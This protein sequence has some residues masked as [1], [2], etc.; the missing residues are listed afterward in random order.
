MCN[1]I[2]ILKTT[3]MSCFW[4]LL[5]AK[6][7]LN[8]YLSFFFYDGPH[9]WWH[10]CVIWSLE[11]EVAWRG[12]SYHCTSHEIVHGFRLCAGNL[13]MMREVPYFKTFIKPY[14]LKKVN[15][16]LDIPKFNITISMFEMMVPLPCNWSFY[17]RHLIRS[18]RTV[19]SFGV[20]TMM[21]NVCCPMGS[22]NLAHET[23]W[24]MD[25]KLFKVHPDS[26]N[27]G[28]SCM[29]RTSPNVFMT[30]M[31]RWW[32]IGIVFDQS[33]WHRSSISVCLGHKDFSLRVGWQIMDFNN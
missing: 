14:M 22:P 30:L 25:H 28:K 4:S 6:G 18:Q 33:C 3:N 2:T 1:L 16:W 21:A 23:P 29:K 12:F 8:K 7:I 17:A 9:A 32:R 27:I 26:L 11:H 31:N 10:W 20:K 24:G 19:Y 5:V 13:H 15:V